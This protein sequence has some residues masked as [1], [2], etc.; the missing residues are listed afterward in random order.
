MGLISSILIAMINFWLG[1]YLGKRSMKEPIRWGE[2]E[3]EK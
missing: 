3:V 1:F 2:K